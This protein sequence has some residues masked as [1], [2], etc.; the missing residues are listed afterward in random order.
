MNSLL[1]KNKVKEQHP[2]LQCEGQKG[3]SFRGYHIL[4][5]IDVNWVTSRCHFVCQ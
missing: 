1:Y 3:L 2:A 4:F 5:C